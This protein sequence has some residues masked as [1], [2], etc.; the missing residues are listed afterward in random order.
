MPNRFLLLARNDRLADKHYKRVATF[1]KEML[2][3]PEE[4]DIHKIDNAPQIRPRLH[5]EKDQ[6]NFRP[7]PPMK[8]G[9]YATGTERLAEVI[10]RN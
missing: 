4:I 1:A 8:F 3:R 10:L 7:Q 6:T 2:V 5:T 9:G